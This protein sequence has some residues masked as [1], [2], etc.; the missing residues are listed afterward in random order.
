M[1]LKG[2][3]L[4]NIYF[5]SG[6]EQNDSQSVFTWFDVWRKQKK[7]SFPLFSFMLR[8]NHSNLS[9]S[10]DYVNTNSELLWASVYRTSRHAEFSGLLLKTLKLNSIIRK[11][12][13]KKVQ[14]ALWSFP[15]CP[16][17]M[18]LWLMSFFPPRLSLGFPT[19]CPWIVP[20]RRSQA[21][22]TEFRALTF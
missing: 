10:P 15:L 16:Y 19:Y 21:Q 7:N 14:I 17:S 3:T 20:G 13:R 11:K 18:Q 2:R 1:L 22:V 12:K 9:K 5:L 4:A 6:L 8:V